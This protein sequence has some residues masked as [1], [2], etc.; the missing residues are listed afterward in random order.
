MLTRQVQVSGPELR[1]LAL[2]LRGRLGPA[3]V[4]CLVGG[5]DDKPQIVVAAGEQAR[6]RGLSAGALVRLAAPA[7]GGKGGGKDN[8]AQGGGTK[9]AGA[10]EAL[11][12]V[13]REITEQVRA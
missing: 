4:V 3:S 8:L 12:V 1:T 7:I 6:D 13:E 2:D 11:A 9:A 10:G 5:A